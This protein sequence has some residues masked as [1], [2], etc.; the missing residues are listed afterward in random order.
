MTH[1]S[2]HRIGGRA[3]LAVLGLALLA[4]AG[5]SNKMTKEECRL[6]DWRTIG[7]EDGVAGRPGD[8]IGQHRRDCAEHGV[9]P[10][11]DAYLAGRTAGLKEYCQPY[12]GYRAGAG[13]ATYYDV[14]PADLAPG[15]EKAY[16]EGRALYVREEAVRDA[17]AAIEYR[18]QE[19]RRLE[20]RLTESA[21]DVIDTKA[22][23]ESRTQG[24]LDAKQAAERIAQLKQEI[25]TFEVERQRA[26]AELDAYRKSVPPR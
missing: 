17:E 10:D 8:R 5:C 26:Q 3:W 6:V 2:P 19:V 22:T 20:S 24:A 23:P 12:N 4:L 21:F 9:K 16:E 18:R 11:L 1:N 14:C 7:Y 13:G 15:F 25:A